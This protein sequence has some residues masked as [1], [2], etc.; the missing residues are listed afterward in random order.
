MACASGPCVYSGVASVTC[1]RPAWPAPLYLQDANKEGLFMGTDRNA[2]E[3]GSGGNRR[4]TEAPISPWQGESRV[5][6]RWHSQRLPFSGF[7]G[8]SNF[9]LS[10]NIRTKI[11]LGCLSPPSETLQVGRTLEITH[12]NALILQK[13]R[14]GPRGRRH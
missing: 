2:G 1:L 6:T 12:S 7:S 5:M 14:K 13:K 8:H 10:Y 4:W 3:K 9:G 11:P